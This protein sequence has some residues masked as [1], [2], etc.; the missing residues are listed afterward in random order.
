MVEMAIT[1]ALFAMWMIIIGITFNNQF[2]SC[3]DLKSSEFKY[4]I[5][6][7]CISLAFFFYK[8]IENLIKKGK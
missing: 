4:L 1:L 7:I 8:Y 2:E 5:S 6:V 3:D